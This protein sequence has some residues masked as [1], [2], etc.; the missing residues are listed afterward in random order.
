MYNCV[1]SLPKPPE[2]EKIS[3]E[4]KTYN[5]TS[6]EDLRSYRLALLR[7]HGNVAGRSS[8]YVAIIHY[9]IFLSQ[10]VQDFV[11]SRELCVT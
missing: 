2:A 4:K 11:V 1:A 5:S 3:G 9:V 6:I 10:W 8:I 7:P